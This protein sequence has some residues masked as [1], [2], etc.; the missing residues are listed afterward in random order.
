MKISLERL[1][2]KSSKL[3]DYRQQSYVIR[4]V[5]VESVGSYEDECRQQKGCKG[6]AERPQSTLVLAGHN[7]EQAIISQ[8][9]CGR[10]HRAVRQL[11]RLLAVV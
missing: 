8:P 1:L 9:Q 2:T 3:Q 4:N 5:T 6:L 7:E 10:C 11:W